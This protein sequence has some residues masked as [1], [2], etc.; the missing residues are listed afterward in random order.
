MTAD[1]N[2]SHLPF[3][4]KLPDQYNNTYH[5]YINKKGY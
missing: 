1:D 5:Y 4:N 2:K 3:L